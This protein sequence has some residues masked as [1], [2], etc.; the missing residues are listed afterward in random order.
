MTQSLLVRED[1]A[2]EAK[3]GEEK[4]EKKAPEPISVWDKKGMTVMDKQLADPLPSLIPKTPKGKSR[5]PLV[6]TTDRKTVDDPEYY[7]PMP[8]RQNGKPVENYLNGKPIKNLKSNHP[9]KEEAPSVEVPHDRTPSDLRDPQAKATLEAVSTTMS[10]MER[11]IK[12]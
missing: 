3:E 6:G 5:L 9:S 1:P 4:E 8:I 11:R 7:L 10:P 2:P 12:K